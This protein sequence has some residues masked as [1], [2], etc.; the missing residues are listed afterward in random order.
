MKRKAAK[1]SGGIN[2]IFSGS[3][4]TMQARRTLATKGAP[5]SSDQGLQAPGSKHPH[6]YTIRSLR[7][8]HLLSQEAT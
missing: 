4:A 8:R 2:G 6:A 5:P 1:K 7:Y 3:G